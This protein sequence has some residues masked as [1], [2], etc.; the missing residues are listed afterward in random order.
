MEGPR[1]K[2]YDTNAHDHL[3]EESFKR[4]VNDIN[5]ELRVL[6]PSRYRPHCILWKSYTARDYPVVRYQKDYKVVQR[7]AHQVVAFATH[8]VR[9]LEEGEEVSHLCGN[10]L[11]IRPDHITLESH[12][13][14]MERINCHSLNKPCTVHIPACLRK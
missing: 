8:G 7:G 11:C 12:K 13:I 4:F 6:T 3:D 10:E 5:L 2:T 14:N 9:K 1:K